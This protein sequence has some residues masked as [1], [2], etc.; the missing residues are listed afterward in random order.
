VIGWLD[1]ATRPLGHW[2]YILG[3]LIVLTLHNWPVMLALGASLYSAVK[4]YRAPTRRNVQ[5]FYGWMLLVLLYEYIKHLGAYLAEPVD[6]LLT[7]DWWW[8]RPTGYFIVYQ[9]PPPLILALALTLL[10]KGAGCPPLAWRSVSR[11]ERV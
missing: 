11:K 6:F 2:H 5:M 7:T 3:Y 8:M 9:V 1:D 4:L 10:L